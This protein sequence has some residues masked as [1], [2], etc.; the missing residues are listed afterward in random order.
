[1]GRKSVYFYD[2]KDS[3]I[4][5]QIASGAGLQTD[6]EATAVIHAQ[7]VQY[8]ATDWDFI[9]T[10]AEA[11]GYMV[12]TRDGTLVVKP[13]VSSAQ[14][15]LALTY[16]RNILDFEAVIDSRDQFDAVQSVAWNASGQVLTEVDGQVPAAVAPG[17]LTGNDL[18]AVIGLSPL[19]LQHAGQMKESELQA[20]AD[21][22]RIR[23]AFAKVRGRA[24]IQGYGPM[25]P[26]DLIELG[27]LG[28]RFN[29]KA[30]VS[31]LRHE[32]NTRNWETEITFGLSPECLVES[33]RRVSGA[34]GSGLLPGAVGLHVGLVTALEGDPDGE[35]RIQVRVPLIGAGEEGIWARV[36]ALDAGNNRGTFFRPEIDDEVVLG[37]LG[38]DPTNPIVLG[39]MNSSAKP[40]PFTASDTNP[41]KGVVT[42]SRIK[43]IFDDDKKS[44][45]IE[46]PGGNSV[47]LD[48]ENGAITVRDQS[49]NKLVL[50]SA[51]ITIESTGDLIL[52]ATGDVKIQ[53]AN[54]TMAADAQLQAK[55]S[56][57]AEF[58]SGGSTVLKGSIVQ[59]N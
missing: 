13:P 56:A 25:M 38:E 10:R 37:F 16:G 8:S 29:G 21:G 51:G 41:Q 17:N 23:S 45:L 27:G 46:T 42:R 1:V 20:W 12:L 57:G 48:D 2:S 26:G 52:K 53:G 11:N 3:E 39:M 33:D 22:Q 50:E 4:M 31:G 6:I 24:R 5:E 55:G 9:V 49:S 59:I 30:L 19:K 7:M 18:A 35:D 36:A 44:V 34:P 32:I 43:V 14:A 47:L 54:A 15:S 58:S 40:A 28:D